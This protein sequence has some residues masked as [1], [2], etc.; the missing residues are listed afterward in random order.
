M[1]VPSAYP[2]LTCR[3][4]STASL[5][6]EDNPDFPVAVKVLIVVNV[7]LPLLSVLS[8]YSPELSG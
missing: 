5:S 6:L 2:S 3:Q 8:A 4:K 1:K 7:S